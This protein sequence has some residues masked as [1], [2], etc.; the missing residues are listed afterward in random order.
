MCLIQFFF[1]FT[2]PTQFCVLVWIDC[3]SNDAPLALSLFQVGAVPAASEINNDDS[4]AYLNGH[5]SKDES[6][7]VIVL[8]I[9]RG[10]CDVLGQDRVVV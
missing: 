3:F 2:L 6:V 9:E 10:Q 7:R 4:D 5:R 1:K 8:R